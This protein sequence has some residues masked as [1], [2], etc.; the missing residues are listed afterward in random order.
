MASR[1]PDLQHLAK[2]CMKMVKK[3]VPSTSVSSSYNSF[4][5]YCQTS[6]M[7]D[8]CKMNHIFR[9]A[10][11][12]SNFVVTTPLPQRGS[13]WKWWKRE[14]L[15]HLLVPFIAVFSLTA[16]CQKWMTA[17]RWATCSGKQDVFQILLKPL[18]FPNMWI[19]MQMVERGVTFHIFY[20]YL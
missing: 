13:A 11:C 17:V 5:S 16:K 15:P 10:V 20:F 1:N 12:V 6:K 4:Q 7:H 2:I 18:L 19:C 14:Y 9:E 8:S 3:K